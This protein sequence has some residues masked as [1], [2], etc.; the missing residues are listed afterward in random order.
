MENIILVLVS[1]LK[2][3]I[4]NV[5]IFS[6]WL[7]RN[8]LPTSNLVSS[9]ATWVMWDGVKGHG[10]DQVPQYLDLRVPFSG[11]ARP[12]G[13]PNSLPSHTPLPGAASWVGNDL[14]CASSATVP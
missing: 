13:T 5:A 10:G 4:T 9:V 11:S 1:P 14:S 7:W 2:C 8:R 6:S 12:P 3:N